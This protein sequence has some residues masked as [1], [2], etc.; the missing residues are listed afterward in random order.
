MVAF[1]RAD[2]SRHLGKEGCPDARAESYFLTAIVK[3]WAS[4]PVIRL[5]RGN[6]MTLNW[7]SVRSEHISR[8]CDLVAAERLSAISGIVVWHNQQPLPAKQV[9]RIAYRLANDLPENREVRFSS[10]DPTLRLLDALG[11]RA[12]RINAKRA[13]DDAG[14]NG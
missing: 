12:E 8:A 6:C 10:G 5:G 14:T 9:L 4:P 13:K 1:P 2:L 7:K 3:E 11:F